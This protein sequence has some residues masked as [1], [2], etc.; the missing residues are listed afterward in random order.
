M[1]ITFV[2]ALQRILSSSAVNEGPDATCTL[3]QIHDSMSAPILV[4]DLLAIA[5]GAEDQRDAREPVTIHRTVRNW[6]I[7]RLD[8]DPIAH[9]HPFDQTANVAQLGARA[10]S[11][12]VE[13]LLAFAGEL[14]KLANAAERLRQFVI[15]MNLWQMAA[16]VYGHVGHP[17][18]NAVQ[19]VTRL[20]QVIAAL[21]GKPVVT[22][23]QQPKR[24]GL[25]P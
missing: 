16:V 14:A 11:V 3:V 22:A 25:A 17:T 5:L 10:T 15:A 4:R 8:G 9:V 20:G 13:S 2:E 18:V 6:S 21:T 1:T 12:D 7:L 19:E 24:D 23:R